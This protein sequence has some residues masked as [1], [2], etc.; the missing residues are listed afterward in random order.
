[1]RAVRTGVF[2]A[3]VVLLCALVAG[4]GGGGRLSK[5]DYKAKLAAISHEADRAQAGVEQ[6][7]KAT[8]VPALQARLVAF[9]TASKRIGDEVGKL[10]A[11]KDAESAN[12]EL[13]Q[14]EH[15]TAQAT[16][17]A[18]AGIAKLKTPKAAITYLQTQLGNAKGGRELDDALTKL[19]QLGYTTGS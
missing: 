6:G 11:P 8:T 16:E 10:K 9:A 18:A 15:D 4:C 17:A 14:G 13:A 5:S 19:K 12:A 7:L 3:G 2:C 1:V